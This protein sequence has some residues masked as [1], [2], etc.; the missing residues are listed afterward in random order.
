MNK[1]SDPAFK[2][3]FVICCTNSPDALDVAVYRRFT[4]VHVGLPSQFDRVELFKTY[5]NGNHSLTDEELDK[6][7][8]QTNKFTCADVEKVVSTAASFF[9][10]KLYEG[11]EQKNLASNT[12]G[13]EITFKELTFAIENT[14]PSTDAWQL[15][16]TKNFMAKHKNVI[17]PKN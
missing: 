10:Q 5:L 8:K 17:F 13:K 1:L 15:F 7:A 12:E 9:Y 14:H 11:F 6:L 4:F 16:E 2:E 3:V